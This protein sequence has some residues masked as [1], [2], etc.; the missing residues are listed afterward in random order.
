ME[1]QAS[2]HVVCPAC[3]A[4]VRVPS[5]RLAEHPH[6]P[7]CRADVTSAHPFALDDAHFDTHLNRSELPLVVDFWAGWCGPCQA[8][9]PQYEAAAQSLAPAVRFAKVDVDASPGVAGRYGIRSIPT[10]ILFAGGREVARQAGAMG[11]RD[12][13]EWVRRHAV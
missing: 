10:M 7:K 1:S 13:V 8:M 9:A 3:H 12:I 11:A 4:T 6:C 2:V 5:A